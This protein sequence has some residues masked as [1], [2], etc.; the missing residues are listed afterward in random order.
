MR[1]ADWYVPR[2]TTPVLI[3][4]TRTPAPRN[5][6]A[7]TWSMCR[8]ESASLVTVGA[9][10]PALGATDDPPPQLPRTSKDATHAAKRVSNRGVIMFTLRLS[11]SGRAS[12]HRRLHLP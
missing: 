4:P 3:T 6:A 12:R 2:Y 5:P 8:I 11:G 1:P 10:E 7:R 9:G